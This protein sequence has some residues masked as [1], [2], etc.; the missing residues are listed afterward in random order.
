M[1]SAILTGALQLSGLLQSAV[2]EHLTMICCPIPAPSTLPLLNETY[3]VPSRPTTGC[4]P[5]SWSH[6]LGLS[7]PLPALQI[8]ALA[9]LISMRRDHVAPPS[10]DWLK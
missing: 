3:S 8:A 5:W 2:L 7:S 10:V 1:S 6:A 9:P 4:E